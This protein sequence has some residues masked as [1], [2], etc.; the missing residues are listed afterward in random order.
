MPTEEK[1][2]RMCDYRIPATVVTSLLPFRISGG[3][4]VQQSAQNAPVNGAEEGPHPGGYSHSMRIC[5]I[6]DTSAIDSFRSSTNLRSSSALWAQKLNTCF[7]SD[8]KG[9]TMVMP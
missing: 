6:S 2:L 1:L 8:P 4:A 3:A 9:E 7:L 5:S